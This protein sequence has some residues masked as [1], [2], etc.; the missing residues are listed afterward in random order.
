M[1]RFTST[2]I[3]DDRCKTVIC[4]VHVGETPNDCGFLQS[5]R[6]KFNQIVGI[7]VISPI[8][9]S[10]AFSAR[11]GD[12]SVSSLPTPHLS[13]DSMEAISLETLLEQDGFSKA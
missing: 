3:C 10:A 5:F 8:L 4:A 7:K 6:K 2:R 11:T 1:R 12:T 13:V 9:A